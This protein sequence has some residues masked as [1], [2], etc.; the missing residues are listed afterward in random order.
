MTLLKCLQFVIEM[1]SSYERIVPKVQI[2]GFK[3]HFV[4]RVNLEVFLWYWLFTE[5][6]LLPGT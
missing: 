2:A 4:W 5:K 6:H 1:Y 3:N